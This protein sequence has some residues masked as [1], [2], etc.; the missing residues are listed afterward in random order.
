MA[1]PTTLQELRYE[2]AA[3]GDRAAIIAYVGDEEEICSFSELGKISAQLAAGRI[4]RGVKR[5]DC[6]ALIAPNSARW[7]ISFWGIIAAGAVAMPLDGQ[8]NDRD[9]ARM[10]ETGGCN[11]AFTSEA[12]A[13]R[14][15]SLV[16]S[17]RAIV[18]DRDKGEASG[19]AWSDLLAAPATGFPAV[20]A[21]D[22][23]VVVFTSGTTGTPK[24]VP[25][26]HANLLTNVQALAVTR[27]VGPGDRAL[28]PLPLY[29]AYPLTIGMLTPLALGCGIVFPAGVSGPELIAA[30]RRGQ[31]TTLLGVPRLYTALL[32]NLRRAMET[33][34]R[35]LA[36]LSSL[37]LSLARQALHHGM[38]WP[39]K[40]LLRPVRRKLAPHLRLLVSGGAA[41][42]RE[43][44]ETLDAM[45][46]EMLTG[47]GLVETS[48]MLTFNPPGAAIPGSAGKPVPGM[49]VRI[50]N[51]DAEGIGEIE[52]RGPSLFG[53]YRGD[54]AKTHEAFTSDGW[55]RTGDLGMIDGQGYLHIAARKSETIV[56][57][58]GKK[59][60]PEEF[61]AIYARAPLIREIALLG[62]EGALVALVVPDFAAARDSGTLR[63]ADAIHEG[64]AAVASTLP[65]HARLSGLAVGREAL[66]RTQL[67]KIRRH[68]LPPLYEA[69][70]R[71]EA[72][73]A[74]AELSAE[75]RALL[76][77]PAADVVWRWLA[78]RFPDRTLRLDTIPQLD[79]AID[80]LGWVDLTL[81]LERDLNITLRESEIA[82]IVTLRDLLREAAN[83]GQREKSAALA[84]AE[85]QWLAPLGLGLVMLR[86]IGEVLVRLVM[87]WAFQLRVEGLDLLPARDPVLICPNHASYLDPFALGA[88]L[89]NARLRRS[90]WGG[91]TGVAFST[92]LRRLFSRAAQIIP[93]DPDRAAASGLAMG[94]SA[95]EHGWNLVWFPEGARSLD[96]TL[97]RFLPGIGVLVENRPVP[98][99]PVHID[100]GFI[101]LPPGRRFPRFHPITVRFGK[102]ID[103]ANF[104]GEPPGRERDAHIAAAVQEAVAALGRLSQIK[105]TAVVSR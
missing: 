6:I 33:Q 35:P 23:A 9:L 5:G 21:S 34:P 3:T 102:P 37:C 11:L 73:P 51:P 75:D 67:G 104:L 25:L 43:V 95:L 2:I 30:M 14:L 81:A 26:T 78:Q 55:F 40:I 97:Q 90:Y 17:C 13:Q 54:P 63:L 15:R 28:L 99:V 27:L 100:G 38:H 29:H 79:L 59:L 18:L 53:G 16:P 58:D 98:I 70:R 50:T 49:T 8:I 82:R 86:A 1:G 87:R 45:G 39:G 41:I 48:S 80:S 12:V 68:L 103:P 85:A 89:P 57:A 84:S 91:W 10:L 72:A 20:T 77:I 44:E 47:Y 76:K 96:G 65:S 24:A 83:A 22:V 88:A 42:N 56:L 71:H 36:A 32:D 74:P 101:A 92:P 93:V 94:K 69:A 46:W 52:A 66:P 4:Q 31:V 61:E 64:L 60:F 7:I 105:T 62:V 19:E